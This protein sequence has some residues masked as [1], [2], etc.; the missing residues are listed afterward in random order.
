[1][2]CGCSLHLAMS[3]LTGIDGYLLRSLLIS[4]VLHLMWSNSV[5][6]DHCVAT[7]P[8]GCRIV[9]NVFFVVL[10]WSLS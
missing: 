10:L 2:F 5:D 7:E 8:N 3:E 4:L 1:M 9:C 6:G